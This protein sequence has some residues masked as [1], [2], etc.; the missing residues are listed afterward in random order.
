MLYA[1]VRYVLTSF[2]QMRGSS[3]PFPPEIY[4]SPVKAKI[5]V[6]HAYWAD[7]ERAVRMPFFQ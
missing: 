7:D 5:S 4:A 6:A 2:F 3:L 1:F